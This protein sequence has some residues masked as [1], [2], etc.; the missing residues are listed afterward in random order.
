MS[1]YF[2]GIDIGTTNC[3]VGLYNLKNKE[4]IIRSRAY[5]IKF[6]DDGGAEIDP[7][8][9]IEIIS[10]LIKSIFKECKVEKNRIKGIAVGGTNGLVSIDSKGNPVRSAILLM[11]KRSYLQS[12]KIKEIVGTKKCFEST[13]NIIAPGVFSS[14]IILWIKENEPVN[15][16]KTFKFLAPAGFVN[17][18]LTDQISID[19]SRASM[20]LLFNQI[21]GSWIKEFCEILNID[22]NKLP[23]IYSS[24]EIIGN[25][26]KK[27]A[28][29]INLP[30]GIP[31]VAGCTDTLAASLSLGAVGNNTFYMLLGTTGRICM[32]TEKPIFSPKLVNTSHIKNNR[33]LHIAAINSAGFCLKWLREI[34]GFT[35]VPY[36]YLDKLA[37]SVPPGS[38]NLIF[39]PY[40]AGERSPIWNLKAKGIFFGLSASTDKKTIIRS[41]LEG[42]GF[43]YRHNMEVIETT[44]G[45]V[46]EIKFAGKGAKSQLWAQILSDICHKKLSI[47][48]DIDPET[49]GC[50]LLAAFGVGYINNLNKIIEYSSKISSSIIPNEI[51]YQRYTESFNLYK[52]IYLDLKKYFK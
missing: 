36:S 22:Y 13:G 39:I 15:Y 34:L 37:S 18:F 50:A 2:I 42:V 43:A 11:D 20:T 46:D 45:K 17:Y 31:V 16:K 8:E 38:N 41:V 4:N 5:K 35:E 12:Q 25:L 30:E 40:L 1:D 26:T 19:K 51:N 28:K 14:P 10:I 7:W 47:M 21:K 48:E 32:T 52:Q 29:I 49:R 3:K 27:A 9:W 6:T 44:F 33:Y 23:N 24:Y